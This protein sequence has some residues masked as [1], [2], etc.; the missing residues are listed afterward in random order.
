MIQNM[1][2]SCFKNIKKGLTD[3]ILLNSCVYIWKTYLIHVICVCS[4]VLMYIHI[5]R[6]PK[7]WKHQHIYFSL[8]KYTVYKSTS[9]FVL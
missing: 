6:P 8:L 1:V 5:I 4:H 3:P 7:V 9:T 2:V